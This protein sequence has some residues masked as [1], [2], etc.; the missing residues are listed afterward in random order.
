MTFSARGDSGHSGCLETSTPVSKTGYE[1][2]LKR[3]FDLVAGFCL[4]LFTL[5]LLCVAF[6]IIRLDSDGPIFFSQD[7]VGLAGKPFSMLKFRT[8]TDKMRIP[9]REILEDDWEVTRTGK[10]L[11]RSK[12]DEIPQLI[13][14]LR[15]DMSLVG[16]RPILTQQLP[17]LN[18]TGRKRLAVRPGLTGFAQVNGGIWMTWPER[19]VYD[20]AYCE[21]ISFGL[22]LKIIFRTF[23]VVFLGERRFLN[24]SDGRGRKSHDG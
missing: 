6:V 21:N 14:V 24:H 16:P 4:L 3:V 23:A 11:R 9:D 22:D 7:R 10:L 8:M 1:Q 2:Y 19:W 18:E 13:N 12:L 20:A 17:D 15:G 5:P